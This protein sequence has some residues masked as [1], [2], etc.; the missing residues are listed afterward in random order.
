MHLGKRVIVTDIL[1]DALWEDYRAAA[2]LSGMRACW[3]TPIWSPEKRVLGSFAMYYREPRVPRDHEL[4]MIESAADVAGVAIEHHHA[5]EALRRSEARNRAILRAIPD[6]MFVTTFDGIYLDYH[7]NDQSGLFVPPSMFLGRSIE[8]VA[9][10]HLA[11]VFLE[12]FARVRDSEEPVKVEYE[13]DKRLYEACVVACDGDKVLS[14]VRDV[15]DRKHA[16]VEAATQRLELAHLSRVALVGELA[17]ALAHELSQPLTAILSNAQAARHIL[18]RDPVD[19]DELRLALD[20]V[21]AS[22]RR[23]RDFIVRLRA[24]LRK[25]EIR[26]QPVDLNDL[27]REV[28]DLAHSELVSRRV[29]ATTELTSETPR[30]L[31]DKVQL[32]QVVL[33]LLLNA[34]EAMRETPTL[35]K[36]VAVATTTHDRFVELAVSDRGS[37]IPTDQLDRVFEPFVTFRDDGLGLGLAISRSIVSTHGGSIGA[38]NNA[39]G[40][41]TFRCLLP[42]ADARAIEKAV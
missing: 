31:G 23:A 27:V 40:G 20:D 25:E 35:E 12:T 5:H 42:I 22:D 24:M 17:G 21:I 26:H 38:E 41:A 36:C 2:Q 39:R 37:G 7:A 29:T 28:V 6:W 11:R 13:H 34:C 10:P 9:P 4:E 19:I 3:S 16:E 8:E 14:I 18:G 15:T 33:N 1:S 30:V 32:Q